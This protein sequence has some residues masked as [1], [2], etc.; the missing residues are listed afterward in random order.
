LREVWEWKEAVSRDTAGLT[1]TEALKRMHLEAEAICREYGLSRATSDW[2]SLR[3]AE[4]KVAY[5]CK[6]DDGERAKT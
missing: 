1:T 4:S 3:V 2:M 6:D 5:G